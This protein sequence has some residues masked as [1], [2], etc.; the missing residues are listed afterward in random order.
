MSENRTK[1][2]LPLI[3]KA[4]LNKNHN[5][6][7]FLYKGMIIQDQ[8]EISTESREKQA[9]L[10][11]AYYF[12]LKA[13]E[14]DKENQLKSIIAENLEFVAKQYSYTGMEQF[15]EK[16][17]SSAL[18]IFERA[19]NIYNLDFIQR[20]DTMQWYNAAITADQLKDTEK[21]I[22][23]YTLITRYN[24]T[25]WN[26]VIALAKAYKQNG[27]EEEYFKILKQ[28]N[29][30]HQEISLFYYEIIGYYLEKNKT[31]SALVYIDLLER[32][33]SQ[34]DK[35]YYLKGSILQEKGEIEK[36]NLQYKKSL[37]LNANNID[38]NF[39]LAA[40]IYNQAVDLLKKNKK[41][42]SDITL[43]NQ[44]LKQ[45]LVYLKLVKQ[46]EPENKYVL[47]MLLTCYRELNMDKERL[48]LEKQIKSIQN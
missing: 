31:D 12:Y 24:P 39:N 38:A 13:L 42:S 27:Q 15:N 40:N 25:D 19:I 7:L 37:N 41:S 4:L 48:E 26:S 21:A 35:L 3:D 23:Y 1:E 10:D 46:Q 5:P 22:F 8:I 11:S 30:K 29:E 45:T 20:M 36:A 33:D 44:Y 34:N 32:Y 6:K 17:Y 18:Q 14:Y 28:T 2:A 16:R 47:S 43:I 9:I